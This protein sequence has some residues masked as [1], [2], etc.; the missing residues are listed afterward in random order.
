VPGTRS[1]ADGL[2]E[3]VVTDE[4]AAALAR[5]APRRD[6]E[7]ATLDADADVVLARF[8]RG[9]IDRALA[10]VGGSGDDKLARQ[11]QLTDELLQVL[12]RHALI[13]RAQLLAAPARELRGVFPDRAARPRR[14][15]T[16]LATTTLLTLGHG[17]P[18]IGHELACEIDSS[19]RVDALVS[20][21][22]KGGVLDHA[23]SISAEAAKRK[24]EEE[25]ARYDVLLD[26][27]PRAIDAE[28]EKA[29]SSSR[30]AP[31]RGAR[32]GSG[33]DRT[34]RPMLDPLLRR[35]F[36]GDTVGRSRT[37]EKSIRRERNTR[38]R[39]GGAF[40]SRRR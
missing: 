18:R 23:G 32:R 11:V 37:V 12:E 34:A 36:E 35:T 5:I 1:L 27:K 22:T 28:F 16:P 26:A 19:D 17:E 25:Y 33:C 2:Y 8:L 24:A 31:R 10:D 38:R 40:V 39:A 20:F 14:P 15:E 21:V 30:N 3:D 6:L 7:V 29:A 13:D 9:L 4:L